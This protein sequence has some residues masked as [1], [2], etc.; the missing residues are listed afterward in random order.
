MV[1]LVYDVYQLILTKYGRHPIDISKLKFE[2]RASTDADT[3][4]FDTTL[5]YAPGS[6]NTPLAVGSKFCFQVYRT[7]KPQP[8][9]MPGCSISPV[10]YRAAWAKVA[11]G[12]WFWI[13][14][15]SS[16]TTFDVILDNKTLVTCSISAG[17]CEFTL[18]Q[19]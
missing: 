10:N 5:W 3:R 1:S 12:K 17:H 13:P 8:T 15:D 2:Q 14:R 19:A 18:P 7:D 11:S 9:P 4:V 6:L 16:V